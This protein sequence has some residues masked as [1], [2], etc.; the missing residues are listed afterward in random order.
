MLE[1]LRPP[2]VLVSLIVERDVDAVTSLSFGDIDRF[3]GIE[4]Q[5]PNLLL[6]WLMIFVSTKIAASRENQDAAA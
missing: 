3:G 4:A 2:F 1:L 5:S 6:R